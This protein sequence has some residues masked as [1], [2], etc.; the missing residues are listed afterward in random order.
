LCL[1]LH[2]FLYTSEPRLAVLA[3]ILQRLGRLRSS[4]QALVG[5]GREIA[6]DLRSL[7]T[8]LPPPAL[9]TSSWAASDQASTRELR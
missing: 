4:G 5:P 8:T 2:P 9:D 7:G 1:V 6:R 3:D